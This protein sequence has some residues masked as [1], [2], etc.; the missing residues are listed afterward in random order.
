MPLNA[1]HLENMLRVTKA[2]GIVCP[3]SP[4]FYSK[5]HDMDTLTATVTERILN[6][7]GITV[8]GKY[9]WNDLN[10]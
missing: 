10:V 1:I 2:G 8:P 5:P 3:A 7:A 6:L 4:S 9:E